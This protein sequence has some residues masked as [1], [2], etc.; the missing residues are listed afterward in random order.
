MGVKLSD[1][2]VKKSV[3][4][5]ELAGKI[6][7][8]D[9][10]NTLY[11]FLSSIRQPEGT[12]LMDSKKRVT[13]HL[14]GIITRFTN[15]MRQNINLAVVLDGKMPKLKEQTKENRL[16]R[17]EIAK[18]KYL[19]AEESGDKELMLRYSK[20]F[21]YLS[22]E[23]IEE[24]ASLVKALGIPVIQAP[25]EADSQMA[26]MNKKGDAYACATSD[27]DSL[28]HGAP[29]FITNLT[30]S[31]RKRLPSGAY[32]NITPEI[33]ELDDCLKHLGITHE[34]LIH[35]GILSG[36]DYNPGGI[37]GIGPKKALKLVKESRDFGKMYK[38]LNA[39]FDWKEIFDLFIN[40]DV[41]KDYKLEWNKI[42]EDKIINILVKNH[43]F[44]EER[45]MSTLEKLKTVEKQ[46]SQKGLNEWFGG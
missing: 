21:L 5:D 43:E 28:L 15:L 42:D 44:S 27:F 3:T 37:K 6:F 16:E 33:I 36:T 22:R 41:E 26:Y 45:V 9:F 29:R 11:Q 7:A 40:M 8:V 12:L 23:M 34:Q 25:A 10:S 39:D 17:K 13:S 38:D 35:I 24:G 4:F 30:V 32:V 31:Q 1:L 19:W 46:K 2:V 20:Q 14:M 18:E